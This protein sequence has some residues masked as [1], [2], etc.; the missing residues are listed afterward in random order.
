MINSSDTYYLLT[1][2]LGSVVAVVDS[3]GTHESEQRY[4]PYGEGRFTSGITET[5][6][7]LQDSATWQLLG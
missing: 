3:T 5:G 1:D 7:A 4:L 2:H 6:L